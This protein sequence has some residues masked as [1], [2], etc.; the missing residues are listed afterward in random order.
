VSTATTVRDRIWSFGGQGNWLITTFLK[1][2]LHKFVV[3]A[4][5]T[6]NQTAVDT[7]QARVVGPP[8][9]PAWLA[10]NWKSATPRPFGLAGTLQA[11]GRPAL[12]PHTHF[13]PRA[14]RVIFLFMNGGCSHVDS[15]DPKPMLD[16]YDGQPLPGGEVKTE[17]RTGELMKSPFKFKKYGQSGLEVTSLL[18]HLGSQI[19]DVTVRFLVFE[20]AIGRRQRLLLQ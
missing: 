20:R 18:P 2:G 8:A 12:S 4:Y 10:G 17:R 7:V 14:K 11:D 9:P 6:A 16:K 3:R 15:F 13:A 5:D 19:D 1:P